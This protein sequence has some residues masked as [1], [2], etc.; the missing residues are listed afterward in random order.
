MTLSAVA[1]LAAHVTRQPVVVGEL[2][3]GILT[4]TA[5]VYWRPELLSAPSTQEM[6]Q[7]ATLGLCLFLF[8]I[9][10]EIRAGG[11]AWRS[12]AALAVLSAAI[13]FAFGIAAALWLIPTGTTGGWSSTVFLGVAMAA[14][15][16]PVLYRILDDHVVPERVRSLSLGAAGTL[17]LVMWI[18]LGVIIL[19]RDAGHPSR[20]LL[21]PAAVAGILVI[22]RVVARALRIPWLPRAVAVL[23]LTGF[24]WAA[25]AATEVAGLHYACGA[26]LAGVTIPRDDSAVR[27]VADTLRH[28]TF[29]WPS[30]YFVLAGAHVDLASVSQQ[31]VW[32]L[33]VGTGAVVT[34]LAGSF[35][36]AR[37]AG[38]TRA[39]ARQTA[40][41]MNTRGLT[42]IVILDLGRQLGLIALPTYSALILL[43]LLATAM[44]SPLLRALS[45]QVTEYPP[46]PTPLSRPSKDRS[47]TVTRTA[48]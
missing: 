48:A 38:L 22:G 8:T 9:G 30:L 28:G 36:G 14:T 31:G 40:V 32:V 2:T 5:L 35:T 23:L 47:T 21:G 12:S 42:E 33:L 3:V 11:S 1:G 43:T 39:E 10:Q 46:E 18:T 16:L 26:M 27:E 25:A 37:W 4:G 24:V 20:W 34:K 45:P 44:T 29:V 19:A 7:L 13:P 15:A 6:T 41:L 17:D